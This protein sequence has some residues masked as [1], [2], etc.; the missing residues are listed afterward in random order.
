VPFLGLGLAAGAGAWAPAP[1]SYRLAMEFFGDSI[2]AGACDEDGASDQWSDF[3]THD[4]AV[5]FGALTAAAFG[6][7]YRNIAV[8]GMGVSTGWVAVRAAQIWDSLYPAADSARAPPSGWTPDVVL[9]NLGENDDSFPR[10]HAQPFPADFAARY[11]ALGRQIRR[12]YPQAEI[13]LLRGGMFGGAQ[14]VPLRDA[15][16]AAVGRLEAEDQRIAHFVFTHWTMN[17][18][19]TADH[20][21]MAGELIAWLQAQE[22]MR[23]YR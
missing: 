13:V 10:A 23:K 2:T 15:W 1:P 16:A 5:S 22:F 14:S 20:R 11:E 17:H 4:N 7:D 6:A 21:A 19:R 8:S 3:R 12:S 9:V 18:P